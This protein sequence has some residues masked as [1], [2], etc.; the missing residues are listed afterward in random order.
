MV[1]EEMVE[2]AALAVVNL[3]YER[4]PH[5]R[6]VVTTARDYARAALSAV[7]PLIRAAALKE[8]ARVAETARVP[9]LN[10]VGQPVVRDAKPAE[11]A[12]LL[13]ALAKKADE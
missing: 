13:L 5:H 4:N 3:H 12:A 10:I 2:R 8:A 6:T 7:A 9:Y 11:I 1:S